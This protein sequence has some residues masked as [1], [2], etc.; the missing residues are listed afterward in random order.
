MI[1]NNSALVAQVFCMSKKNV[2]E[3]TDHKK[4]DKKRQLTRTGLRVSGKYGMQKRVISARFAT[5]KAKI[6]VRM[7]FGNLTLILRHKLSLILLLYAPSAM[8]SS[9]LGIHNLMGT[10]SMQKRTF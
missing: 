7:K 1:K 8:E 5:I 2:A 10:E 3:A 9:I 6:L 4:Y